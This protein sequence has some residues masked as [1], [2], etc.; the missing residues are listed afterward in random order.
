MPTEMPPGRVT[1]KRFVH[2]LALFHDY[3]LTEKI[4]R[5]YS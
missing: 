4:W 2:T 5:V 1:M 3:F